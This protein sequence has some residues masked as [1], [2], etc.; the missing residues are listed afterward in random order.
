MSVEL[1]AILAAAVDVVVPA[2]E[3][4]GGWE[5]GTAA[6]LEDEREGLLVSAMPTLYDIAAVLAAQGFASL[7]K[8]QQAE[9]LEA[10]FAD[11]G[12]A[13]AAQLLRRLAFEGFYAARKGI[14]PAGLQM[15]GFEGL[16]SGVVPIEPGPLPIITES[17]LRDSYDVIV[18]GG[19]AG[20]GVV[21]GVLAEA[22]LSVLLLE[23]AR[24]HTNAE[25]RGDHLR[26][27]RAALYGATAGAGAGHPRVL[28]AHDG[29]SELVDPDDAM[30]WGLNAMAVGG[31]TRVW[32]GMA[33][34]FFEEDFAMAV[35]YGTPEGSTLANWPFDYD[36]LA[37]YYDRAEWEIGVSG[38]EGALTRRTAR[39]R[40]Y[41]M[42][43]FDDPAHR[44]VFGGAAERLG[45]GWGPIPFS[46]N[47]VPRDGRLACVRC[48]QCVG[49]ACPTDAKN[50]T[51]NTLIKRATASGRCDLLTSAQVVS[52]DHENGV[53]TSVDVVVDGDDGPRRHTV[54]AGRIVVSAGAVETPRLLLVS[55]LGNDWVGR[56]LHGH[57]GGISVGLLPEALPPRRGPGHHFATLDFVHRD[58]EAWGGGVLFDGF[59]FLPVVISQMAEGFG[60]P[61][62]GAGHKTWM[63]ENHPR[64]T[65]V[66]SIAQEVPSANARVSA[67]PNVR[68][69]FGMPVARLHGDMHP[70]SFE[71]AIYVF[72]KC[73]AWLEATGAEVLSFDPSVLTNGRAAGGAGTLRRHL[74]DGR[75]S[76]HVGMRSLGPSPRHRERLRRRRFAA[77]D[78]RQRQPSADGHGERLPRRRPPVPV[79][80]GRRADRRRRAQS[81]QTSALARATSP[82][83]RADGFTVRSKVSRSNGDEA[84]GLGVA[85]HPLEVVEQRPVQVAAHVDAVGDAPGETLERRPRVG[86]AG[87]VVVGGHAVLGDE[88]RDAGVLGR[89]AHRVAEGL[90]VHLPA[91]L[92][93]RHALGDRQRAVG[94]DDVAGV[95]LHA[96]PVV[97]LRHL[98]PVELGALA[99]ARRAAPRRPRPSW[100]STRASVQPTLA[101]PGPGLDRLDAGRWMAAIRS[102]STPMS[103]IR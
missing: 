98:E 65:G 79:G 56:N 99:G 12:L 40:G 13:A 71:T 52:I 89:Q 58:G 23:R 59:P 66:M 35:H 61:A 86:E 95:G 74:Q 102:M 22:G 18:V 34:R 9:V 39:T 3:S 14:E 38:D 62:F 11:P 68:D 33:W 26:G 72:E 31:G 83:Q 49:H 67:D 17:Q 80:L 97:V 7:E 25:L 41:P 20:G 43:A 42:P 87:V 63:R 53:A 88:H 5:G 19:G 10:A 70:A 21:A 30:A 27:K 50:G 36:E 92:H 90:G 100:R 103:P 96:D 75:R 81:G 6:F 57:M 93:R 91:G 48:D 45:W 46:L 54:R 15:I 69:R 4:P 1:D 29:S 32:Q 47:S 64:L 77:P 16:P 8:A 51:H 85:G 24:V 76:G 2:D 28:E 94:A 73:A 101:S 78:Q 84:E 60:A 82:S 55:G 37:P 44:E